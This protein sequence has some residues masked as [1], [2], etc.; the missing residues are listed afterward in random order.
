MDATG[1]QR[2]RISGLCAIVLALVLGACSGAGQHSGPTLE[3]LQA[4]LARSLLGSLDREQPA[5]VQVSAGAPEEVLRVLYEN[6]DF[7]PIWVDSHGAN[8]RGRQLLARLSDADVDALNP[9]HYGLAEILD[10]LAAGDIDGLASAELYFS[11][12]LMRYAADLKGERPDDAM[13]VAVASSV[14]DFSRYLDSLLPQDPDYRR[15]RAAM[16]LYLGIANEGG[17]PTMPEGPALRLGVTDARILLLRRR[18]GATGDLAAAEARSE[19]EVFDATIEA[20]LRR[21]QSRHGLAEDGLVGANTLAALNVPIADRIAEIAA[22]LEQRRNETP[23]SGDRAVIVNIAAQ[24][25]R[26]IEDG[27]EI[28]RSRTIIGREGWETPLLSSE[29]RA[30]EINPTWTVPRRIALEE[31]LP[32][33]RKAGPGYFDR[34]GYRLFDAGMRELDTAA[35]EWEKISD[36]Y[37]PYVLR[38]DAG[39]ANALGR[40]KFLFP[41]DQ[42][43]YL[44]DT[45]G[46]ALFK[47][48]VR[49]FSHGC[50]RVEKADELAVLLLGSGAGWGEADYQRVLRS[51]RTVRVRLNDPMPVHL[52]SFTVW[53]EADGTV[54]FRNDPY[55]RQDPEHDTARPQDGEGNYL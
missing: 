11:R 26:L 49:A 23:K 47:R 17:W 24:E 30:V 12:A 28:L 27:T 48:P 14:A 3:Q 50:V 29:I 34:R 42:D 20:A 6:R 40:V 2:H 41:N 15:L 25:L 35:I 44:H 5:R 31:I 38:Q 10:P 1:R 13:V 39:G 43:I 37:L 32:A 55:T 53:V 7:E 19:S 46:R 18:L 54:Q 8:E 21:F 22:N 52:V 33:A 36:D 51:G 9:E 16:R 45:P 4:A